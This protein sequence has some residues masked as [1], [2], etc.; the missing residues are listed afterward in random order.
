[1]IAI[2]IITISFRHYAIDYAI[3]TPFHYCFSLIH[4]YFHIDIVLFAFRHFHIDLRLLRHWAFITSLPFWL[5]IS[6][7]IRRRL[8]ISFRLRHYIF[9]IIT[10]PLYAIFAISHSLPILC[11]PLIAITPPHYA[12]IDTPFFIFII[13]IFAIFAI[14]SIAISFDFLAPFSLFHI[15]AMPYDCSPAAIIAA[16]SLLSPP[17]DAEASH[18]AAIFA[19][20]AID[21][22]IATPLPPF[23]CA[24][25]LSHAMPLRQRHY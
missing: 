4:W 23:G 25:L 3:T 1:M 17:P 22:A 8:A 13:A 24:T 16:I 10:P 20:A 2:F 7:A 14:F 21:Y 9:A 15:A 5:A 18:Y 12:A 11:P 6:I 19:I